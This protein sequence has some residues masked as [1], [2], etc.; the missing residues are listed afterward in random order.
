M[1][2]SS[3]IPQNNNEKFSDLGDCIEQYCPDMGDGDRDRDE[4]VMNTVFAIAGLCAPNADLEIPDDLR[5]TYLTFKY[6]L[7]RF[8]RVCPKDCREKGEKVDESD[9]HLRECDE[10]EAEYGTACLDNRRECRDLIAGFDNDALRELAQYC[11]QYIRSAGELGGYINHIADSCCVQSGVMHTHKS[12]FENSN[13]ETIPMPTSS[14][15][16]QCMMSTCQTEV[17]ACMAL[18]ECKQMFDDDEN[19]DVGPSDLKK[20]DDI[21]AAWGLIKCAQDGGCWS[22]GDKTDCS[23]LPT[24]PPVGSFSNGDDD[25]GSGSGDDGFD[26]DS[27]MTVHAGLV[28]VIVFVVLQLLL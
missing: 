26:D 3:K 11:P 8:N 2:D 14:P 1:A 5:C 13:G 12:D 18:D 4:D 20:T 6:G 17:N 23:A 22:V 25:S 21:D 19:N 28:T 15:D 7:D 9:K 27:A 16:E 24:L 10:D